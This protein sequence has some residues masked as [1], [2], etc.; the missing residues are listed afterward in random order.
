[1][2]IG[3]ENEQAIVNS[4]LPASAAHNLVL[5]GELLVATTPGQGSPVATPAATTGPKTIAEALQL[6]TSYRFANQSLEFAMRDLAADVQTNL[7]GAPFE[8]AIKI[9]GADLQSDGI[10]RN[11]SIR[12]F[13]QENQTVADI[14]TALVLK[15]NPIPGKAASDKDQKL[16]WVI[17]PDPENPAKQL[18]LITTRAA[19]ASKKYTLP[20]PFVLEVEFRLADR[21]WTCSPSPA[22]PA[23]RG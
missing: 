18:V 8:F 19:A 16:I 7:K 22:R 4:V 6:K 11:Q 13:K 17:G 10:T 9:I 23:K 2:R 15:A 14:L 20:A 5:G 3:V 1:M 12:D 21:S